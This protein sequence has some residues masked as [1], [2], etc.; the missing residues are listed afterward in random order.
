MN[1]RSGKFRKA[2]QLCLDPW[3][4]PSAHDKGRQLSPFSYL[5]RVGNG[6]INFNTFILK[7]TFLYGVK[8]FGSSTFLNTW[9]WRRELT[10]HIVGYSVQNILIK[11]CKR[12]LKNG[13]RK[14][15]SFSARLSHHFPRIC[16]TQPNLFVAGTLVKTSTKK[17]GKKFAL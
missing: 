17:D 11:N 1:Y 3:L 15:E 6:S 9:R 2:S 14:R 7:L 13:S 10:A 5:Y 12:V 4:C 16:S 8:A